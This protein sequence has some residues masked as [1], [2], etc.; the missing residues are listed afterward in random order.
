MP[1]TKGIDK[2]T[3]EHQQISTEFQMPRRQIPCEVIVMLE[4][5]KPKLVLESLDFR[6]CP[7]LQDV[8]NI[9]S[10]VD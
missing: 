10:N 9:I 3:I 4:I 6:G 8:V 5:P 7:L 1:F 2:S